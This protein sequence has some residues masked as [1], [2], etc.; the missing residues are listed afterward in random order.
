MRTAGD[1]T[2]QLRGWGRL[3]RDTATYPVRPAVRRRAL[4]A[5][6]AEAWRAYLPRVRLDAFTQGFKDTE[7][8]SVSAIPTRDHNCSLFELVT[9]ATIARSVAPRRILEIGT[10]DGRSIL[11]MAMNA[12]ADAEVVTLNLPPDHVAITGT[13]STDALLSEKVVSGYRALQH[14]RGTA[15]TQIF[16]DS[17]DHDFSSYE[18]CGMVFIDGA[19]DTVSA[20][21]DSRQAL[22]IIDRK[23]GVIVWHDATSYGVRAV[24]SEFL[25]Q[26][27]PLRLIE[28]T[29]IAVLRFLDGHAIPVAE[30]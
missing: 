24:T 20:M 4:L 28:G 12:P 1:L 5:G 10:Y 30:V 7:M 13:S 22:E 9:L 18:P 15:V 27:L 21:S 16:G 26:G 3:L 8:I 6:N 29:D 23:D 17:R 14:P 2:W 19:H 11:A 25:S